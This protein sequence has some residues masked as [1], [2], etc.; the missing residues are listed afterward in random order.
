MGKTTNSLIS[1]GEFA[2]GGQIHVDSLR[3]MHLTTAQTLG[4]PESTC[5][6]LNELLDEVERLLEG[7]V[8]S[9][10]HNIHH[11]CHFLKLYVYS[12]LGVKYIGELTPR[13]LD[14]LVSFGERMSVRIVSATL[15]KMGIPSLPFDAWTI[16]MKTS[17][18]F[19]N[20]EVRCTTQKQLPKLY[21]LSIYCMSSLTT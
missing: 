11:H 5:K 4:L 12:S 17:S 9:Y 8:R 15:N 1:A 10:V 13:T 2:L 16:G 14:T 21:L 19:G 18:E 7:A 20:A 6:S 3:T